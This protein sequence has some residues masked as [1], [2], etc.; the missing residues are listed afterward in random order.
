MRV[1]FDL[2]GCNINFQDGCNIHLETEG[3]PFRFREGVWNFFEEHGWTTTEF[4]MFCNRAADAG[5]LFNTDPY[6]GAPEAFERIARLGHELIIITDRSFGS[7][8][9]VSERIT[10]EW[11]ARHGYEYDE[12][13]FS[14]DKTVVPT[15]VFVEDKLQNYDALVAAGTDCYLID[16]PWNQVPGGDARKRIKDMSEYADIIEEI[17][18]RGF[19][20]LSFA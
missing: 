20:D 16:R 14:A 1:G 18:A 3:H 6:P 17:T 15:D 9:A 8:P 19:V 12:L 11:L 5:V 13:I 10:T 7:T 4:V 2:D